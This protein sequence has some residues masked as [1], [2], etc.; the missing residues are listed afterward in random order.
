MKIIDKLINELLER[1]LVIQYIKESKKYYITDGVQQLS[2]TIY[3][4][5]NLIEFYGYRGFA[6]RIKQ[7]LNLM[8]RC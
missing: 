7:D 4:L 3:E 5:E 6:N 1:D 2:Y 8:S